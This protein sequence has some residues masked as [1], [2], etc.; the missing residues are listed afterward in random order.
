MA[1]LTGLSKDVIQAD[2]IGIVQKYS[3]LW[4]VVVV[5]KGAFTVI[6]AP[7]G[8]LATEPFAT[9]AL[10]HAGTGDV[11]L[12]ILGGLLAQQLPAWEAAVL[13]AYLH[14]RAGEMAADALGDAAGVQAGEV[15]AMIPQAMR[16]LRRAMP[17]HD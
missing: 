13:A 16:E 7:D 11:L 8:R 5:L 9:S 12:G 10:A 4:N 14:G 15:A 17:C 2:R 6:A 1:A 3:K